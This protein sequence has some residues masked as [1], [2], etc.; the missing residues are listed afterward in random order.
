MARS[1][2]LKNIASGLCGAFTSRNND[3]GGYWAIG[4]LRLLAMQQK[5]TTVTLDVLALSMQ[6]PLPAFAAPLERY[7]HLLPKLARV[8]GVD[9]EKISVAVITVDFAPLP[10]PWAIYFAP[11]CGDQFIVTVHIQADGRLD[12]VARFAGYCHPHD[13]ARERQSNRSLED[14]TTAP[15]Q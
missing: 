8:S 1:A 13:P 6:P 5:Q 3:V 7:H 9:H 15:G 12:G 14:E 10:W 4:I 2:R 11:D